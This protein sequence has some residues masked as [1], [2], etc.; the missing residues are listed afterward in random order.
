M[1]LWNAVSCWLINDFLSRWMRKAAQ[2][3]RTFKTAV[4]EARFHRRAAGRILV[5]PLQSVHCHHYSSN[6]DL[7]PLNSWLGLFFFPP[8]SSWTTCL[9]CRL[10]HFRVIKDD[11]W[12]FPLQKFQWWRR[13]KSGLSDYSSGAKIGEAQSWEGEKKTLSASV[14]LRLKYN[15]YLNKQK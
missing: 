9:L 3:G 12:F 8:A 5:G 13:W 7:R 6:R 10:F 4:G 15:K 14:A 1:D 11:L 2:P